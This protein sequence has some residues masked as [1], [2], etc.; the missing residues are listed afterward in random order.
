VD[1][2][3]P[4]GIK[5]PGQPIDWT[6]MEWVLEAPTTIVAADTSVVDQAYGDSCK[7]DLF[8]GGILRGWNAT[9][10]GPAFITI[11]PETRTDS[12][13]DD[14]GGVKVF[15]YGVMD[16][17]FLDIGHA[18]TLL[19][20]EA[21]DSCVIRDSRL[22]H[23]AMNGVYVTG[24]S[25]GPGLELRSN[26][27]LRGS[28]IALD[29]GRWAVKAEGVYSL[30]L[31]DNDIY[32]LDDGWGDPPDDGG[33]ISFVGSYA[34]C[35][36]SPSNPDS[37]VVEGN[38]LVGPG[39]AETTIERHGISLSW[40]CGSSNWPFRID[41]NAIVNWRVGVSLTESRDIELKCNRIQDNRTGVDW[42]RF[43]SADPEV[44][45]R[46]NLIESS[47]DRG[48]RAESDIGKLALGA[49][50]TL[51]V[52]RGKNRIVIDNGAVDHYVT[53]NGTTGFLLA[54][55][56]QWLD[57]DV[58]SPETDEDVIRAK[59]DGAD[60]LRVLADPTITTAIT[61]CWPDHP[62]PLEGG[63]SLGAAPLSLQAAAVT[64]SVDDG[65]GWGSNSGERWAI[66]PAPTLTGI[67]AIWPNPSVSLVEV[68][69]GITPEEAG[70]GTL[71][72]YDV[73]GRTVKT[74]RRGPMGPGWI[75]A[76]WDGRDDQGR[77]TAS[78]VYF[79]HLRVGAEQFTHK[80]V[81]VRR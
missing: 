63:P 52:D 11:R 50:G 77:T 54:Q 1:V 59:C 81:R 58:G 32:D 70:L 36:T 39:E 68:V 8:L 55:N 28:G 65:L 19:S 47:E 61:V 27:I 13:A 23:Y 5:E 53:Q 26:S 67:R 76:A 17:R 64:P 73:T 21:P 60:T 20:F 71:S 44:A 14:W 34:H 46:E 57:E 66:E 4:F 30:R 18:S 38:R 22:H 31:K 7:V 69:V 9:G 40:A 25:G 33:A 80:F 42:A 75:V 79:V 29:V 48:V 74:L 37:I 35:H 51:P 43:A 72:V 6:P 24:S 41:E 45:L 15:P 49:S 78:G 3:I 56:N 16:M 62:G 2:V 10:P 12:T